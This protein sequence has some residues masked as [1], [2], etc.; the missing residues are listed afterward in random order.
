MFAFQNCSILFPSLTSLLSGRFSTSQWEHLHTYNLIIVLTA[1]LKTIWLSCLHAQQKNVMLIWPFLC[2]VAY[3]YY[4]M[5]ASGTAF[6]QDLCHIN[7]FLKILTC[8]IKNCGFNVTFP[9]AFK[10]QHK[11]S[12]GY[13]QGNV[14]FLFV[15]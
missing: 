8:C 6:L 12:I 7:H 10:L 15:S 3:C 1:L 11:Y 2:N 9:A 5:N 13:L 4:W 14:I